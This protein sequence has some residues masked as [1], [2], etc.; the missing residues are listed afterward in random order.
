[1]DAQR[2]RALRRRAP[3]PMI[4]HRR[5]HVCVCGVLLGFCVWG[6]VYIFRHTCV[7]I[8][9]HTPNRARQYDFKFYNLD[10]PGRNEFL[11]ELITVTYTGV[12]RNIVRAAWGRG[13]RGRQESEIPCLTSLW[14]TATS[15]RCWV[16]SQRKP[17][18][19]MKI[20]C[21]GNPDQ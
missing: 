5:V 8:F 4:V 2:R 16:H 10:E 15:Q 1:M 11:R 7:Y 12:R 19:G 21:V 13:A 14:A 18:N 17:K 6:C 20:E 9:H 3:R